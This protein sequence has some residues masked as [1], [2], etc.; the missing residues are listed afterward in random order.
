MHLDQGTALSRTLICWRKNV[1]AWSDHSPVSDLQDLSASE[2]YNFRIRNR[3]WIEVLARLAREKETLRW[4]TRGGYE[5]A[6]SGYHYGPIVVHEDG[7][8]TRASHN[9]EVIPEV[10]LVPIA[11]W[12]AHNQCLAGQWP[13]KEHNATVAKARSLGCDYSAE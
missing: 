13:T 10:Y 12:D 2:Y 8:M 1:R 11:D 4:V 3:R 9:G 7:C 5:I 6:L